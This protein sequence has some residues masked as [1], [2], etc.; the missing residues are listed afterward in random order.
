M[1]APV[2]PVVPAHARTQWRLHRLHQ[3][4]TLRC[5]TTPGSHLKPRERRTNHAST[6]LACRSRAGGNPVA[7]ASYPSGARTTLQHDT[8]FPPETR[9]RQTH[10]ASTRLA[11]RSRAGG[12]PVAFASP[13]SGTRTPLQ[14]DAGFPP[15]TTGT[16]NPSSACSRHPTP[17]TLPTTIDINPAPHRS[18]RI[19]PAPSGRPNW[20]PARRSRSPPAAALP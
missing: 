9:Q 5:S 11:C 17:R 10:H 18:P 1:Q 4:H 8:G 12:N 7:F 19:S 2:L 16:T 15:E 13:P 14:H 20:R 3:A 6:R